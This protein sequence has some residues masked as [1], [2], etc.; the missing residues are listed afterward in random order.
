MYLYDLICCAFCLVCASV[1]VVLSGPPLPRY[2]GRSH[3]AA[4]TPNKVRTQHE[5]CRHCT[6]TGM[7]PRHV[8][9]HGQNADRKHPQYTIPRNPWSSLISSSPTM[10]LP[11]CPPLPSNLSCVCPLSSLELCW[12]PPPSPLLGPSLLLCRY[13]LTSRPLTSTSV[14]SLRTIPS[15][16]YCGRR[17]HHSATSACESTPLKAP[18]HE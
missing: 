3:D 4:H 9:E 2:M 18:T 17:R 14:G 12:P 1:C 11:R 16:S 7:P 6:Y 13:L 5:M 15:M 8:S 10:R